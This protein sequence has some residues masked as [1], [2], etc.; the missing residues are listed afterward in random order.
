MVRR[1]RGRRRPQGDS[2]GGVMEAKSR[3][4]SGPTPVIDLERR[5][6][7]VT[8][9]PEPRSVFVAL[10]GW[11]AQVVI[12]DGRAM[13][14]AALREELAS[15]GADALFIETDVTSEESTAGLARSTLQRLPVD[16]VGTIAFLASP[17]SDFVTGQ[18]FVVDGGAVTT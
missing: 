10:A 7:V 15:E 4:R 1:I 18:T 16:L 8:G 12:A 14:G 9:E 6:A 5:V 2:R 17:A 13:E 3:E 11:G